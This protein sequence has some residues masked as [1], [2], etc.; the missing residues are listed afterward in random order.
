MQSSIN[1]VSLHRKVDAD[2]RV[3]VLIGIGV[4]IVAVIDAIVLILPIRVV[5]P[6]FILL[7]H[8]GT[9]AWGPKQ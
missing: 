5:L 3:L 1:R 4:N 9:P 6:V 8:P 7:A 2:A